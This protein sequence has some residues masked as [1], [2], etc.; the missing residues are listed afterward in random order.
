MSAMVS[1]SFTHKDRA[2]RE[3]E[4]LKSHES[5]SAVS[6]A[7]AEF[8]DESPP[9]YPWPRLLRSAGLGRVCKPREAK[10]KQGFEDLALKPEDKVL[11]VGCGTGIWVDRLHREF[12]ITGFGIDISSQSLRT[13]TKESPKSLSFLCAEGSVLPYRDGS[14]DAVISLDVLEHIEDQRRCLEEMSRVISPGGSLFLW[15]LNRNQRF[16]WNWWLAQFGVDILDRVAHDPTRLPNP[17]T[18]VDHLENLGLQI[19]SVDLFNSFFTLAA[20]EAIMVTVSLL[21]KLNLFEHEG[22][23]ASLFGRA[24]LASADALSRSLLGFLHWLDSPWI[25]RG[26]SNGFVVLAKKPGI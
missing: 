17:D 25:S 19:L 20:D 23:L 14:F 7:Q 1:R 13:A 10:W 21:E 4:P 2:G 26:R 5:S 18:V 8:F 15:T 3:G 22:R 11:D 9:L 6:Q 24:F 16:T 12:G